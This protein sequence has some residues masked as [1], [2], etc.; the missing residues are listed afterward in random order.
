MMSH[1]CVGVEMYWVYPVAYSDSLD[2]LFCLS[3]S[4]S[5][6]VSM[7]AHGS[8]QHSHTCGWLSNRGISTLQNL[9]MFGFVDTKYIRTKTTVRKT[10][11]KRTTQKEQKRE[12]RSCDWSDEMTT[13]QPRDHIMLDPRD[14][15]DVSR[16][17]A[18][19]IHVIRKHVRHK[20]VHLFTAR[21]VVKLFWLYVNH[22]QSHDCFR[23]HRATHK[24]QLT[25]QSAH[26]QAEGPFVRHLDRGPCR[27]VTLRLIRILIKTRSQHTES[28]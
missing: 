10:T 15:G 21:S 28:A 7:C 9:W 20:A 13:Y 18:H 4:R 17:W 11:R 24:V 16:P 1:Q 25:L 22:S 27:K 14:K 2:S 5:V 8:A 19:L 12:R 3:C 26:E 23:S 6:C